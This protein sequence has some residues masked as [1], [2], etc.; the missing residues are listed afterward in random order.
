MF[1][2]YWFP[3]AL[4]IP[5]SQCPAN[6]MCIMAAC[7]QW[8]S[9]SAMTA[10]KLFCWCGASMV[11]CFPGQLTFC[12]TSHPCGPCWAVSRLCCSLWQSF[13]GSNGATKTG[14]QQ[15]HW[16]VIMQHLCRKSESSGH[17]ALIKRARDCYHRVMGSCW[18]INS[19]AEL[20]AF[21]ETMWKPGIYSQS[22]QHWSFLSGFSYNVFIPVQMRGIFI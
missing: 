15:Y 18:S 4:L 20:E 3:M 12:A 1:P 10:A 21:M 7:E 2:H 14:L 16:S 6:T 13:P 22:R 8:I 11:R 17:I 19:E 9:H 5:A